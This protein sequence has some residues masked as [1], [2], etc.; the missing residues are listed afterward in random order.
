MI[1]LINSEH[2]KS[3]ISSPLGTATCVEKK[4]EKRIYC[5]HRA[6][7]FLLFVARYRVQVGGKKNRSVTSKGI[8]VCRIERKECLPE[9]YN[10]ARRSKCGKSHPA[11]YVRFFAR[12]ERMTLFED[13]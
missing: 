11:G 1:I 13:V 10:D 2:G 12:I 7:F 8:H 4:E 5:H 6:M 3:Y 9:I